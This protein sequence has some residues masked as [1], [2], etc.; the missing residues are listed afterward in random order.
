M[1]PE[2]QV[3]G[4]DGGHRKRRACAAALLGEGRVVDPAWWRVGWDCGEV[5][6]GEK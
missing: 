4:H 2:T 3:H 1:V 5:G 6:G